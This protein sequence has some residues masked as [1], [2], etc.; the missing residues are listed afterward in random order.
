MSAFALKATVRE[1]NGKGAA[2]RLRRQGLVPAVLYGVGEPTSLALNLR[3]LSRITHSHGGDHA[4]LDLDV[5]GLG[6]RLAVIRDR[7]LDNV[8]GVVLH[9]DLLEVQK[10]HQIRVTVGIEIVGETPLGVREQGI[11]QQQLHEVAVDCLPDAIP[12]AILVDAAHL[13]VGDS[14]HVGDVKLPKGVSIH[15]A[16]DTTICTV[17]APK[18]KDTE[19]TAAPAEGEVP[20]EGETPAA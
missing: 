5:A 9:C 8:T 16:A 10:G 7:Q 3:E 12:E 1:G 13:K 2:R 6:K 4:V 19:T 18:L 17:L 20:A 14:L 15:A 11:L